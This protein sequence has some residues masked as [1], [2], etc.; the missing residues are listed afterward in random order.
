MIKLLDKNLLYSFTRSD[1][2]EEIVYYLPRA[3]NTIFHDSTAKS[4]IIN[5]KLEFKNKRALLVIKE[6]REQCWRCLFIV[7]WQRTS[8]LNR[9]YQFKAPLITVKVF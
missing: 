7:A 9:K 4:I 5:T 8:R 1:N 3:F 2:N 6:F